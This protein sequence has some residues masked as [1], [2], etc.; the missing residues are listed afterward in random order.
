M[1]GVNV[2]T[3][4]V[5]VT[6]PQ[7]AFAAVPQCWLCR[8]FIDLA[9]SHACFPEQ[10]PAE[11]YL[12]EHDHRT[13]LGDEPVCFEAHEPRGGAYVSYIFEHASA[14]PDLLVPSPDARR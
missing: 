3:I 8:H 5:P 11:I 10:V 12:N 2:R 1:K 7:Q 13:P 4:P 6:M 14:V 9:A